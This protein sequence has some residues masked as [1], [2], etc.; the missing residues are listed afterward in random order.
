M[1]SFVGTQASSLAT[2]CGC[3]SLGPSG[4]LLYAVGFVPYIRQLQAKDRGFHLETSVSTQQVSTGD[5]AFH[6][7]AGTNPRP[8]QHRSVRHWRQK[9]C[10]HLKVAA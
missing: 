5:A 3:S 4:A 7:E 1:I 9:T 6:N 2:P 10:S 8:L